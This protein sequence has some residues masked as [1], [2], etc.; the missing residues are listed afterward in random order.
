MKVNIDPRLKP[1]WANLLKLGIGDYLI[2]SKFK[3]TCIENNV[4]QLWNFSRQH[5]LNISNSIISI[6]GYTAYAE[7]AL[8]VFLEGLVENDKNKFI[9]I[10]GIIIIDFGE[11]KNESIDFNDIRKSLIE[12]GY[13]DDDLESI[14]PLIVKQTNTSF[15]RT[16]YKKVVNIVPTKRDIPSSSKDKI[17]W[18][19]DSNKIALVSMIVILLA[20]IIGPILDHHLDNTDT[21]SSQQSINQEQISSLSP[22]TTQITPPMSQP[23]SVDSLNSVIFDENSPSYKIQDTELKT[24]YE[25]DTAFFFNSTLSI[26]LNSISYDGKPLRKRVYA[27]IGS[28]GYDI[29]DFENKDVGEFITY[30]GSDTFGIQLTKISGFTADFLVTRMRDME[31]K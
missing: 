1:L 4:D 15:L 27:K 21:F 16:M 22:S 29:I 3:H 23:I 14:S 11:W 9:E 2:S 12:I 31:N 5:V 6:P 20:A 10:L 8:G 17:P 7:E 13:N 25:G 24:I 28:T 19:K 18:Y 30:N 26:S